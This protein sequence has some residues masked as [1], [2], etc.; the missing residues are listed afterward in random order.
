[1]SEPMSK[2]Q[3]QKKKKGSAAAQEAEA[4]DG[5]VTIE[6][7]GVTLRVG[8]AGKMPIAAM[9]AFRVGDNYEGTKLM[10]GAEQWKLLS[11]A[12]MTV[13]DL[14]DLGKKLEDAWG[15]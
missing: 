13:D 12:G 7:C 1:M 2:P 15:N 9:D 10:L 11:D 6:Q 14:D 4:D 3:D 8:V 5:F